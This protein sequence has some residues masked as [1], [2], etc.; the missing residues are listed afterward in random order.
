MEKVDFLNP[1]DECPAMPEMAACE[2]CKF[3]QAMD[4]V[5]DASEYLNK[6]I[7]TPDLLG[8]QERLKRLKGE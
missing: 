7:L 8:L 1:C 4:A 5:R 6:C 2:H 3:K